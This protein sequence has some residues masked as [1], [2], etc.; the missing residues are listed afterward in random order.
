MKRSL[1]PFLGDT[2]SWLTDTAITKDINAIK[3]R[4]NQLISTQQNQQE[5]LVHVIL[6]LNVTR[7]ATQINRQHINI[8][9]DTTE[10]THQDITALYNIMHSLYSS[11]SY[12]QIIPHIRSILASLQDSLHYC[13]VRQYGGTSCLHLTIYYNM[14]CSLFIGVFHTFLYKFST[15]SSRGFIH[16]MCC[17]CFIFLF[18]LLLCM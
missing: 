2:L 17:V 16:I 1:L 10:M 18:F 15:V 14:S 11:I 13:Y 5:T 3:S 6:T 4:I 8:L 12:Q 9:M 7:Y